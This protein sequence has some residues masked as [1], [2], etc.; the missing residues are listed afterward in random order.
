MSDITFNLGNL[1]DATNP[2]PLHCRYAGEIRPQPALVYL[3]ES[4]EVTADYRGK[5]DAVSVHEWHGRLLSWPVSPFAKGSA[6][7]A[8]LQEDPARELLEVIH[9]G[10]TV[11]CVDI[12]HRGRLS[13]EAQAASDLLRALLEELFAGDPSNLVAVW[14]MGEWLFSCCGLLSHWSERPLVDVVTDLEAEIEREREDNVV[15]G[16]VAATLLNAAHHLFDEAGGDGLDTHHIA[17]LLA[18]GRISH[19]QASRHPAFGAC[20]GCRS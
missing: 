14:S 15:E 13:D 19:D 4:G 1:T 12:E 11:E 6:L 9:A 10:H 18:D 20:R 16:D 5:S 17:A 3:S 7:A 2:A 8:L